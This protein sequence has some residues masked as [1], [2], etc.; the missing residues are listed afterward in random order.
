MYMVQL[1]REKNSQPLPGNE[2]PI[3]EHEAQRYT[4]EVSGLLNIS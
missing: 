4:T 2:H 1:W 3:I